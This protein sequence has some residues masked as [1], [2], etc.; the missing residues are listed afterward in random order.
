MGLPVTPQ[1]QTRATHACSCPATTHSIHKVSSHPHPIMRAQ[2]DRSTK[3]SKSNT[4][5]HLGKS[6]GDDAHAPVVEGSCNCGS[7]KVSLPKSAFPTNSVLCHCTN[8]R[9]SSGSLYSGNL[10]VE[11]DYIRID[12]T[13]KGYRD[14]NTT[15]GGPV[16]RQ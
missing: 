8:C 4:E 6:A 16:T 11:S 13:P 12:G 15:T 3:V 14:T 10:V 9:K 1:C 5:S 7:I 2:A